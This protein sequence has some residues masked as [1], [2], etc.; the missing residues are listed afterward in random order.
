MCSARV[1][2]FTGLMRNQVLPLSSVVE[3]LNLPLLSTRS[4]TV[5]CSC[6]ASFSLRAAARKRMQT[7]DM[8]GRLAASKS[9]CCETQ[10]IKMRRMADIV[11]DPVANLA[12]AVALEAHPNLE[13]PKAAGLLEAVHIILIPFTGRIQFIGEVG[14]LHAEGRGEAS[15]VLYEDGAGIERSVKPLVRIDGDGV[16][17]LEAAVAHGRF[18]GKQH[19]AAI[20]SVRMEPHSFAVGNRAQVADGVEAPVLVVPKMP[21][22]HM[23]RM[24]RL[25]SCSMADSRASRRI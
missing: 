13:T 18:G 9:G 7:A 6:F 16:R 25:R 10:R 14:G 21:M 4:T 8:G 20:S 12:A 23:G 1:R 17:Q 5:A 24:P 2:K 22:R 3:I 15:L 11:V 19:A